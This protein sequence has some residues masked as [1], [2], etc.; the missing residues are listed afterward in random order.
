MLSR[1]KKAMLAT[2]AALTITPSLLAAAPAVARSRPAITGR[3][4]FHSIPAQVNKLDEGVDAELA[5]GSSTGGVD[6]AGRET[7]FG[8]NLGAA[9]TSGQKHYHI[10]LGFVESATHEIGRQPTAPSPIGAHPGTT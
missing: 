2:L 1:T 5:I 10:Y 8:A 9:A 6:G 7:A 3:P 4:S